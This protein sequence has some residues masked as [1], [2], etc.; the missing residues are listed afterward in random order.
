VAIVSTSL[1]ARFWSGSDPIGRRVQVGDSPGD[2]LII[3]GVARDVTMYNWWDGIDFSA[4][5]VPLEQAPPVNVLSAAV[6]TRTDGSPAAA[7]LRAALT[8]VD[9]LLAVD[10]MRTMEQAIA[11]STFGLNFLA[12]LLGIC[13]GIG[14]VLAA[15][16][17][18][19]TMSY[20]VSQRRHEFGLRMALGASAGAVLRLSLRQ[21]GLLTAAGLAIGLLLAASVGRFM[22]SALFGVIQLDWATFLAVGASLTLVSLAAAFVPALRSV[23]VDPATVLRSE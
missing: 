2:W 13:G 6:R 21:A 14:L 4:I 7:P 1:A 5:Y 11:G 3:V 15:V 23:R 17:I 8:S 20:A 18:Y 10:N 9:P 22:S 16:G 19:S 12:S